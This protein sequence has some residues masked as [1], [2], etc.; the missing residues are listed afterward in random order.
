MP[1]SGHAVT[2][3]AL[4]WIALRAVLLAVFSFVIVGRAS[5]LEHV[6]EF[7]DNPGHLDMFVHKP[8]EFRSG[9]PLVVALHGCRQTAQDVDDETGLVALAEET[10]FVLLLPQQRTT[11]MPVSCFRWYDVDDNRPGRGESASIAAMILSTAVKPSRWGS[12][13][14]IVTRLGCRFS[15]ASTAFKPSP[16]APTTENPLSVAR[17]SLSR[18]R[19]LFTSSTISTRTA[20][21]LAL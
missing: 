18:S 20:I 1:S 21:Q 3:S 11:N 14:S 2:T 6:T 9:L 12:R 5:A 10:P 16:T 19:A 15:T 7:G 17:M 13:I 8:A 4:N